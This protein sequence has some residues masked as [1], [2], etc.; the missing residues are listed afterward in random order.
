MTSRL[1]R[2]HSIESFGASDGPGTRFVVFMQGCPMRCAFCHNPDTWTFDGGKEM[3]AEEL[4][5]EFNKKRPF[6]KG[7]GITVSGGEPL[8][9]AAFVADLFQAAHADPQGPIHT[10]LDTSGHYLGLVDNFTD[11]PSQNVHNDIEHLL[12][13]TDLVL[14]DIKHSDPDQ[15][16]KLT[17][18]ELG[19]TLDFLAF[20]EAK[21]IKTMIRHVVVP[22]ITDTTNELKDLGRLMAR[23]NNIVGFEL[24]PYHTLGA[25][26]YR[27][28]NIPY[29][30][31][32]T[33][34]QSKDALRE[35]R[36]VV[37]TSY[38]RFSEKTQEAQGRSE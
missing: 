32:D 29:R 23:Y 38:K 15:Y 2:V 24:L 16:R 34:E 12:A 20:L 28:L 21:N 1:G 18:K 27:E 7:G 8:L 36:K 14:L 22:G 4:L 31:S 13:H 11:S 5:G 25:K 17:G 35:L 3:S 10:C 33:P 6:Y 9:Q 30:L 19:S 26:K 37:L